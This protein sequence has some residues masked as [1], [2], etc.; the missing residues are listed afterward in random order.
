MSNAKQRKDRPTIGQ[1]LDEAGVGRRQFMKYCASMTALM[2]M[3]P[4]ATTAFARQLRA[5][6]RPSVI[7]MPFQECTGC[8]ESLTRSFAPTLENLMFNVISLDY[9]HTLMAASGVR[10]EAARHQAMEENFGEYILI[11][12]GSIPTKINGMYGAS[13]GHSFVQ[14]L[15]EAAA[16]A[17]AIVAVG[18]CAAYGGVGAAYPNPTGAVGVADLIKDKPVINVPGCPPIPEVM[19]GT[20]V[21]FLASGV[22]ELD[23]HLRPRA[24]FGN[25]IHDRC[26]RRR[27]YD[28]GLFAKTFDD[29]GARNGWCL[30]ELGC[31]GPT[32]YNACA[33]IKWNGGASWPV[34]AGHGCIGC[35]EPGFWDQGGFYEPV[36][37]KLFRERGQ[38]VVAAAAGVAVGAAAAVAAKSRKKKLAGETE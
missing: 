29:E 18:V 33:T 24:F 21:S 7:Y 3:P 30:Y 26:Y 1:L 11:V 37:G 22:P 9:N 31:R 8:L 14:Q 32:T 2:A 10:A 36:H 20:L 16:G 19:T 28:R 27:F 17:A 34:E 23:R 4:M 12:D 25:T 13:D 38:T 35:S 15:E 5:A 6:R